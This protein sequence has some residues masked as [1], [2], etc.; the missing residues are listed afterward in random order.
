MNIEPLE[1][2]LEP[3][4]WKHVMQDIPHYYFFAFDWKYNREKTEILVA[5]ERHRIEGV[6]LVYNERIVQLRGSGEAAAALLEMLDLEK[7]EIQ[8][9]EAY[10]QFV[11]MKYKSTLKQS[12]RMMLMVLR[13]GEE[14]I[15]KRHTTA[16][17]D[18]SHS[19]RIATI[20]R[21]ADP[22]Y[23]GDVT[24]Q[25]IVDGM[26]QGMNWLGIKAGEALV[27]IGSIRLTE[28]AGLIGVVATHEKHRN[29]GYA[30]SVVAE[31]VKR[32]LKKI[33]LAMIFV[34]ADNQPAI[35]AYTKV[36]FKPYKT[37]FFIRGIR[38]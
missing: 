4:F 25:R 12:H 36:G 37:Y 23:W 22:E 15:H 21:D 19:G 24:S 17:L 10:G 30:T 7:V 32:I 9:P 34:L 35:Q 26:N 29:K 28:W 1:P 18:A 31:L 6:M 33:S 16:E 13:K 11:L 8:S 20:M 14:K 2:G 38:R 3:I 5:L 27:S